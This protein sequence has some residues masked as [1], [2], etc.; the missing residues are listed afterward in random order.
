[1]RYMGN[2]VWRFAQCWVSRIKIIK[3][4][5]Y[6]HFTKINFADVVRARIQY[7]LKEISSQELERVLN[8][9]AKTQSADG[10][11]AKLR[12]KL[13][14]K[15]L[16][17]KNYAKALENVNKSIEK[18]ATN[19]TAFVLK[20]RIFAAQENKEAALTAFKEALKLDP[21]N[22]AAVEGIKSCEK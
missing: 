7:L 17:A 8:P 5:A 10:E 19:P 18:D 15:L 2:W 6:E 13:S 16:L 3:L 21:G 11:S 22:A 14:E 20:G 9:S 4:V 12:L 1:M